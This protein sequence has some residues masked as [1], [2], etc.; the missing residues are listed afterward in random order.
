VLAGF[1]YKFGGPLVA[2]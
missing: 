1:A 2:R